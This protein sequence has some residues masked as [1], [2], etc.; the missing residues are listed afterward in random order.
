M[1]VHLIIT[2]HN[3]LDLNKVEF[4]EVLIIK[5]LEKRQLNHQQALE[6]ERH[7]RKQLQKFSM[8]MELFLKHNNKKSLI[9]IRNNHI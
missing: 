2:S 7:I 1:E 9:D 8:K 6:M 4:K 5:W 3:L